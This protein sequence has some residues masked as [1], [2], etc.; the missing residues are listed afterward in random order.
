MTFKALL[1]IPGLLLSLTTAA[2]SEFQSPALVAGYDDVSSGR[3][4]NLTYHHPLSDRWQVYSGI[5]YMLNSRHYRNVHS[6]ATP[7]FKEF[8][9]ENPKQRLGLKLGMEYRLWQPD[10]RLTISGFADFQRT[11]APVKWQTK[12]WYNDTEYFENGGPNTVRALEFTLGLTSAVRISNRCRFLLQGGI[13]LNTFRLRDEHGS[14]WNTTDARPVAFTRSF[15]LA[16]AY[17]VIVSKTNPTLQP[18]TAA[19]QSLSLAVDDIQTGRN[20]N[21]VYRRAL[22][23][24]HSLYGGIKVQI[25]S[26]FFDD[27]TRMGDSYYFKQFRA[28]SVGQALGIKAGYE[29]GK[30]IPH[31][32][33]YLF[34]FYELQLSRAIVRNLV[35]LERY[36]SGP[37]RNTSVMGNVGYP[38]WGSPANF[39]FSGPSYR[40]YGPVTALEN[41]V[42][43]GARM[44]LTAKFNLR[45]QAGIGYNFYSGPANY[46][47]YYVHYQSGTFKYYEKAP[48]DTPKSELSKMFSLGLEYTLGQ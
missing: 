15:R 27:H 35:Q 47:P 8:F 30:A 16:L 12:Y 40:Y 14:Q 31:S 25:N 28:E 21:I 10:E 7:Y 3:N 33:L 32:N 24:N 18:P 11:K 39:H 9:A 41:Y 17:D 38:F 37:A 29:Y 45:L 44:G 48:F 2:Q 4:L 23:P 1:C 13:G 26:H 19:R 43:I 6:V 20:L 42:G 46:D 36:S 34:G 5:K 22:T